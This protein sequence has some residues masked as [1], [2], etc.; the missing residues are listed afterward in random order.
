MMEIGL[1]YIHAFS[2]EYVGLGFIVGF[3]AVF[4]GVGNGYITLLTNLISSF[5]V[6]IPVAILLGRILAMG[7]VGVGYSIP[8]ATIVGSTVAGIFYFSGVWKKNAI[9]L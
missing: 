9:K 2:F 8:I 7:V 3:N 5:V 4:I 1:Q 6:R